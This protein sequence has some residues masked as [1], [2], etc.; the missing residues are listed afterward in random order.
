MLPVL[1]KLRP[2]SGGE[3]GADHDRAAAGRRRRCRWRCSRARAGLMPRTPS[4]TR[5][6]WRAARTA[7]SVEPGRQLAGE[8]A[9]A[10]HQDPVGHAD[11][12]GQLA[13]DHQH[14]DALARRGC[15][16]ARRCACLA[17]TSMPRVG[18]SIST[19]RGSVASQ[20]ARTTFCWLPPERNCDLLVH[21]RAPRPRARTARPGISRRAGRR[22]PGEDRAHDAERVVEDRLVAAPGRWPCGPR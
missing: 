20:R 14:G 21:R 1:K 6:R 11:H 10:H 7:S 2:C 4:P 17:P 9:V 5:R 13:G 12:L 18:S 8:P 15:A 19:T 22:T 16:S 3:D